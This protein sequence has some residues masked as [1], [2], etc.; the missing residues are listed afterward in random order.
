MNQGKRGRKLNTLHRFAQES[1]VRVSAFISEYVVLF[2]S[3]ECDDTNRARIRCQ[4]NDMMQDV[5]AS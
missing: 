2:L 3:G 4:K 1:V 5:V